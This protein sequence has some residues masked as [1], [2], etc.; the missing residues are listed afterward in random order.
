LSRRAAVGG[1]LGRARGPPPTWVGAVHASE[2]GA[3]AALAAAL[4]PEEQRAAGLLPRGAAG[5]AGWPPGACAP[6][7][8]A[9]H[10]LEVPLGLAGA[11]A[12]RGAR[13]A[14][15]QAREQGGS[16]PLSDGPVR[17]RAA[18]QALL[19]HGAQL[20]AL[21]ATTCSRCRRCRCAPSSCLPLRPPHCSQALRADCALAS[22][23]PARAPSTASS[24]TGLGRRLNLRTL[25]RS[26]LFAIKYRGTAAQTQCTHIAPKCRRESAAELA[27]LPYGLSRPSK[28]SIL[29]ALSITLH[30][31][32]RTGA[33]TKICK[34]ER[35]FAD[36]HLAASLDKG[37]NRGCYHNLQLYLYHLIP[38]WTATGVLLLHVAGTLTTCM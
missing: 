16:A 14:C 30:M 3:V 34:R 1:G 22:C 21:V 20:G 2:A 10:A 11:G 38:S 27:G 13:G 17:C 23:R 18:R 15:A 8:A 35:V 32:H 5:T 19:P 33:W 4:V 24:T 12:A 29:L 28:T 26:H 31:A 25:H 36:K 9:G 7:A 37:Y 6:G